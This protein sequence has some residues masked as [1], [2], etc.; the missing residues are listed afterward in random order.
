CARGDYR[1]FDYW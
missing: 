1:N